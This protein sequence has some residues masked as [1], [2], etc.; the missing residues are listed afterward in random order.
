M[1]IQLNVMGSILLY[2]CISSQISLAIKTQNFLSVVSFLLIIPFMLAQDVEGVKEE[3]QT[4]YRVTVIL[5]LPSDLILI[6]R[7]QEIYN[8]P[9]LLFSINLINIIL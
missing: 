7:N 4:L 8:H 3:N 2:Y 1:L 5:W 6:I 9:S